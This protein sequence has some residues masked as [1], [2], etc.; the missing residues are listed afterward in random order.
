MIY[1]QKDAQYEFQPYIVDAM[2]T[3]RTSI[4]ERL[5]NVFTFYSKDSAFYFVN[6]HL[7]LFGIV[8]NRIDDEVIFVGPIA[9]PAT[10]DRNID[11]FLF[12]TGL[13]PQTNEHIRNYLRSYRAFSVTQL[14]ELLININL[15]L[16]DS[17]LAPDDL[18][19]I[20]DRERNTKEKIATKTYAN[21]D[22]EDE[23]PQISSKNIPTA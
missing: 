14:Q 20:Y 18:I 9:T 1:R 2:D 4:Y 22:F 13:S 10:S 8:I 3:E 11:D 5:R 12:E 6:K 17:V 21:E 23:I 7:L 16:N 19:S 15:I